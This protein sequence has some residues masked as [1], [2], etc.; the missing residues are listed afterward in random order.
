MSNALPS[1]RESVA[2]IARDDRPELRFSYPRSFT[3]RAVHSDGRIDLDPAPTETDLR[4][5]DDV[6]QWTLGGAL[7]F[8]VVGAAVVVHF[9]D[10][11]E[12]RPI[13]LGF[14]PGTPVKVVVSATTEIDMGA[15]AAPVAREGG[16][17]TLGTASGVL[18]FVPAAPPFDV[19][20]KVKA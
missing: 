18:T 5:L 6:E 16:A 1:I 3:V 4:P 13:I 17:Y 20:S 10:A 9:R 7:A 14:A 19:P 11:K 15:G 12:T 8:P 2:K